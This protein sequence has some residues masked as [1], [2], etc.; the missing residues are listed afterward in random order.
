MRE[1]MEEPIDDRPEIAVCEQ[2]GEP[3]R[4]ESTGYLADDWGEVDGVSLHRDC[5]LAYFDSHCR[6]D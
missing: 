3:I 4:G 1:F 6:R 2:C 5:V